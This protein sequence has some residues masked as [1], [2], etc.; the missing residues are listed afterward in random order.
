MRPAQYV[1]CRTVAARRV[2]P[3]LAAGYPPSVFPSRALRRWLLRPEPAQSL[4]LLR[5]TVPLLVLWCPE[6]RRAQEYALVPREQWVVPEGLGLALRVLPVS[7]AA[8]SVAQWLCVLAS[9]GAVTGV[10]ARPCLAVLCASATYL[11]ALSQLSGAVWH[12]MHLLWL[13]AL[14][15]ASPCDEALSLERRGEPSP[16]PSLRYGEPLQWARALLAC[17]YFFPGLHKV[18]T[19]GLAWALSDNLRNQLWWKWLEHGTVPAFRLD[20]HPTLLSLGGLFVLAFELGFPLVLVLPRARPLFAAAGLL[21]HLTAALELRIYFASLWLLYPSLLAP[22]RPA[23]EEPGPT[24]LRSATVLGVLLTVFA[25]TQG[26][27]G[28][29]RAFPFACYPTFQW[30]A[31][32]EVP[33][34][35]VELEDASGA[36]T[37]YVHSRD[38]R[39][40]R[41]QRQWGEVWSLAGVTSRVD[42]VRLRSWLLGS[43]R[44]RAQ[45]EALHNARVARFYLGFLAAAPDHWADPARRGPRLAELNLR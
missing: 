2:R 23:P 24:P 31:G 36:R 15:A 14:L 10:Y 20:E 42:P 39:G 29:M 7:P 33:E 26:A 37:L 38:A 21:F 35:L 45:R 43:P 18:L 17:V 11:F 44:S 40:Y 6:T 30:R 9:L 34:L 28:Q 1:E 41:T 27:R 8:A 4:A 16:A 5:I 12:D 19:S 32:P 3:S 25:A 22:A 13:L